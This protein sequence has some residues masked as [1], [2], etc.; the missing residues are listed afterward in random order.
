MPEC[1]ASHTIQ[2]LLTVRN[3]YWRIQ[4]PL[5]V[6]LNVTQSIL[7]ITINYAHKSCCLL[8]LRW[9]S[10]EHRAKEPR[11]AVEMGLG[12]GPAGTQLWVNGRTLCC[13]GIYFHVR[14][15]LLKYQIAL[16]FPVRFFFF[17][18]ARCLSATEQRTGVPLRLIISYNNIGMVWGIITTN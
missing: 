4:M 9:R 12:Q 2:A 14:S 6:T 5:V 13:P 11:G 3:V 15:C 16:F 10:S 1:F 17:T 7:S 8:L 18:N